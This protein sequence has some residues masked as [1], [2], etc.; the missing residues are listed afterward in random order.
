[1]IAIW[2]IR[3]ELSRAFT[4]TGWGKKFFWG[5]ILTEH[6]SATEH[7]INNQKETC[8]SSLAAQIS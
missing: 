3:S 1:M 4:P 2:K 7:Y 5:L 8:R 6:I